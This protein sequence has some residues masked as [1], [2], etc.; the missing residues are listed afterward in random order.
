MAKFEEPFDDTKEVF[1]TVIDGTDLERVINI[2]ILSN[3]KL[4]E[5][6]KVSKSTDLVK[7]LSSEDIIIQVNEEVFEKLDEL[8]QIIV[9]EALVAHIEYNF[10][11]D[12]LSINKPDVMGHSGVISKFGDKVYLNTLEIIREAFNS[13][14]EQKEEQGSEV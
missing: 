4:K 11:K 10:E 12:K 13:L 7:F 1:R 5:I 6:G 14:K 8:Q 2:K 3:N 9:A